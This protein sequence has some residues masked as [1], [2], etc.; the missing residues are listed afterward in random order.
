[1]ILHQNNISTKKWE[2][3]IS[4]NHFTTPFQTPAFF[5]FYNSVSGSSAQVFAVEEADMLLA[6]CVVTFQKEK[7]VK[8][9]FS[10]RAIIYGGPIIADGDKGLSACSFLLKAI[11]HELKHNV[12]YIET[13]NFNDYND[14][15]SCFASESWRYESYLNIQIPLQDKSVEDILSAFKYNRRR[16]I[17]L[18]LK[19]GATYILADNTDEITEIYHIL[20][21]LY[22]QRVNLPL[23]SLDFF[24]K[25]FHSEVG[26]VFVVIHNHKVIGGSFCCYYHSNSIYTM[27]YCG[28]RNYHARIFPTHLAI[29]AAI[30]FGLKSKLRM[31]DLM[32]AGIPGREYGVRKY[33]AEFGGEMVEQG[34]FLRICNPFLYSLG[35][36]GLAILK[37]LT[38]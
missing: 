25:L 10:R 2:S 24:I 27:Y 14:Y 19:E 5:N 6:L 18:S 31:I 38:K 13:R 1:M 33:K 32:G 35:K 30:D 37:K 34:R 8:A 9:Y 20:E 3:F 16:E 11:L 23:P 28:L 26:K 29:M 36:T 12:I 21:E 15:K 7:G 22:K 17:S 4:D